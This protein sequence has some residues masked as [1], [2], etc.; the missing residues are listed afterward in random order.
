MGFR[1]TVV[2]NND[3]A[4]VWTKD[5]RLGA[6]IMSASLSLGNPRIELPY[7]QVIESAHA[8]SETLIITEGYG[9]KVVAS[10]RWW[11]DKTPEQVEMGLL[12]ALAEKHGLK[13]VK[14]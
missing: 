5:E 2:L 3:E 9:G 14:K 1:T 4:H 11:P 6:R 13:V 8:D 7:G 10:S 12:F